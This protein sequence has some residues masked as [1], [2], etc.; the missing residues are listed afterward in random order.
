M[1]SR[2]T[3]DLASAD[4]DLPP[5]ECTRR[6]MICSFPRSGS[7]L[8]AEALRRTSSAGVPAEYFNTRQVAAYAK[9]VGHQPSLKEYILFLEKHRTSSNG[10]FGVKMHFRHLRRFPNQDLALAYLK[11][12][13]S[14]VL[15]TRRNVVAQAVSLVRAGATDMW[16]TDDPKSAE[17][18]RTTQTAYDKSA[19]AY[20]V[21]EILRAER[22]WNA[23]L[24]QVSGSLLTITYEELIS[25]F[26]AVMRRIADHIGMCHLDSPALRE[27]SLLKLSGNS[28]QEFEERFLAEITG[29]AWS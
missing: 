26:E 2:F 1:S 3:D 21:A 19:I 16:N 10:V 12:F 13:Q 5:A 17:R 6:Y 11:R 9:R 7:T 24:A 27:P 18:I 8:I 25:D 23:L 4:Y 28:N 22:A 15:V 14:Y 29:K 20:W